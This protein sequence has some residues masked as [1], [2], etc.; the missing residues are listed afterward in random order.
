MRKLKAN[1][2]ERRPISDEPL[3]L[4]GTVI[5]TLHALDLLDRFNLKPAPFLSRHERGDFGDLPS[6]AFKASGLAV[7]IGER[8][9]SAYN[10]GPSQFDRF[11]IVTDESRSVTT[12]I[13]PG[14]GTP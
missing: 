6:D 4:L 2:T 9:M 10:I 1:S 12:I 14:E 8:I 13:L 3:F 7:K 5:I 11:W